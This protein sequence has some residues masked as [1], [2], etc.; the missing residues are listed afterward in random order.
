MK[1]ITTSI[2]MITIL[3]CISSA[4]KNGLYESLEFQNAIS[5]ETRTRNGEPGAKYWQNSSDYKLEASINTSKNMLKGKGSVLYHNNSPTALH[6]ILFRLYQN[7]YKAGSPHNE[8]IPAEDINEGM[9]IESLKINGIQYIANNQSTD[10]SKVKTYGTDLSLLLKDSI[11]S[12][13]SAMI[14]LEWNFSF[15]TS[16]DQRMGRYA[17]NFFVGLWYPQIAVYDDIVGW[18]ISLHLGLQEFYNDFN[19]YKELETDVELQTVWLQPLLP[20]TV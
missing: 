20:I 17:N 2:L 9:Y 19:N 13:S 12:G 1:I 6:I 3:N 4:Q 15:P 11:P 18:D 5:N 16:R 10:I 14:E 7:L 8:D